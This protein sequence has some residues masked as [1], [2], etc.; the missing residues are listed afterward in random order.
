MELFRVR[1]LR[2]GVCRI[3]P[4]GRGQKWGLGGGCKALPCCCGMV[5]VAG[6]GSTLAMEHFKAP[7]TLHW[8]GLRWGRQVLP[9]FLAYKQEAPKFFM[10]PDCE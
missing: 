5:Q 8:V 1:A 10:G 4:G 2:S 9:L 3:Y 7:N 6:V